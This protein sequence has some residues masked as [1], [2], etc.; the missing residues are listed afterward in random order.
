M[1]AF[2]CWKW[3]WQP[4][5]LPELH[6]AMTDKEGCLQMVEIICAV[7]KVLQVRAMHERCS[8]MAEIQLNDKI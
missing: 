6:Y 4:K 1:N 7:V 5:K 8:Y 3:A 2:M